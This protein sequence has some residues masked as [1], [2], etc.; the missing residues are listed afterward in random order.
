MVDG[1][2]DPNTSQTYSD[3]VQP[4]GH[5]I[6]IEPVSTPAGETVD[7]KTKTEAAK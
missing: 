3:A 1:E 7:A 2:G 6:L 5:S 4:F